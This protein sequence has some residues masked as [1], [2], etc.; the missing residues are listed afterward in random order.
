MPRLI[1]SILPLCFAASVAAVPVQAEWSHRTCCSA[2]GHILSTS[3]PPWP[4]TVLR[5]SCHGGM[6]DTIEVHAEAHGHSHR[7]HLANSGEKAYRTA[8]VLA[9]LKAGEHLLGGVTLKVS[10]ENF[11]AAYA[12]F[13]AACQSF[14]SVPTEHW[15]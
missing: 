15:P 11:T 9:S 8:R 12:D 5:L 7:L 1:H 2:N 4:L 14:G 10:T 6:P 13:K 3:A